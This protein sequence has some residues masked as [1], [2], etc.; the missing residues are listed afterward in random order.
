MHCNCLG[1]VLELA[2]IYEDGGV[3]MEKKKKNFPSWIQEINEEFQINK[4]D[5]IGSYAVFLT[6]ALIAIVVC[7]I[8]NVMSV[9]NS[10]IFIAMYGGIVGIASLITIIITG[11]LFGAH[12]SLGIGMSRTRREMMRRLGSVVMG[13][14]G[15]LLLSS[16][17]IY[18]FVVLCHEVAGQTGILGFAELEI[19]L[20]SWIF[21]IFLPVVGG[22]FAGSVPARFGKKG[23]IILYVVFM[24]GCIAPSLLLEKGIFD[25]VDI[26]IVI[27]NSVMACIAMGVIVAIGW[28]DVMLLKG[29]KVR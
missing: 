1:T 18:K 24:A 20:W 22:A 11:L 23:G 19:P 3:I 8:V 25:H 6:F 4:R 28:I 14:H 26:T 21:I 29:V 9:D 10:Y 12:F 7:S 15:V 27:E 13:F 2:C 16:W 17:M 5:I